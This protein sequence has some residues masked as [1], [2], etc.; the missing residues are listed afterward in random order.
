[1]S[2]RHYFYQLFSSAE[3]TIHECF[4]YP[5]RDNRSIENLQ[6]GRVSSRTG[7]QI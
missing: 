1:M 6:R 7:R 2:D 5:V 4:F 3:N